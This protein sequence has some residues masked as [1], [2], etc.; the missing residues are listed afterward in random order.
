[1]VEGQVRNIESVGYTHVAWKV[2][3]ISILFIFLMIEKGPYLRRL[4]LPLTPEGSLSF[5]R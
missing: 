2:Y 1:M 3:N 5:W 4:S